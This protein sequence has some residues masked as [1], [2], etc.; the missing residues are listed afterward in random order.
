MQLDRIIKRKNINIAI[1]L[2]TAGN[3]NSQQFMALQ[4]QPDVMV[5]KQ[6]T[7]GGTNL[8]TGMALIYC[9]GVNDYIGQ[10]SEASTISPNIVYDVSNR[11]FNSNWNFQ[12]QNLDKTLN[13]TFLGSLYITLEFLQFEQAKKYLPKV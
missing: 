13:T 1:N 5:V 2:N 10:V 8:I 3:N 9:E 7:Y 11:T 12:I 4:F 6:I